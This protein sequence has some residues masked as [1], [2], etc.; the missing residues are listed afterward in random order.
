MFIPLGISIL[1]AAL[2]TFNS[3]ASLCTAALWRIVQRF[4]RRWP[5][6]ARARMLFLLRTLPAALGIACVVFL[7]VPAYLLY[8]PRATTENVSLKLALIAFASAVGIGLST[9]RGIGAWRATARLTADWLAHGEPI[10]VTNLRIP[11]YRIEHQFPVIAIVGIL[12]PRLFAGRQIFESLT[13]EEISAAVEHETGH[14]LAQDNM[15]RGLLRICRDALLIIPCGRSLDS[16]WAEAAEEAAD[17]HAARRGHEVALDLASAL[18]KIARIIPAGAMP[19]MPAGAFLVGDGI[20][21]VRTR[22]RRLIQLAAK[23]QRSDRRARVS[24]KALMWAFLGS[25]FFLIAIT[26]TDPYVLATV[27]LVIERAVSILN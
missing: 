23:D 18:V 21:A 24:H 10:S 2:L 8:E 5:A 3:L 1:L 9:I 7:L 4:T 20:S 11:A 17:E 6:A 16:A 14:V 12:R 22:V 26:A 27:H 13:S 19:I 15:K 25:L